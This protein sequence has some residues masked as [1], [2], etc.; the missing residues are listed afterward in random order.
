[1]A[2]QQLLLVDADPASVRVLEVS[3]K[4]AGFTVT[5]SAD[6]QDALSKLE[7]SAPDLILT[8]TRLPRVDGYE[9]VRRIKDMPGL[10]SIPIVF[11]TSQKSVE[12][13]I[14]GLE[15][16]VED[17]LTKPIFVRE[18]I[19]R[20]HL[21]LARQTHQR[22][23]TLAPTSRRTHL[24]GDLADMGVVDLLQTFE[25]GRKS[26]TATLHDGELEAAIYFRDG[27]VVD[28]EHGK[29]RGEEAIYRCLIWT[30]GTFDVEFEPINREEVIFTSTQGLL[31]EGMRRVDEWGR[32]CEQLPPLETIFRVDGE[33]LAERLNEIPD[34]LNGVLR[35]FD[36][37]RSLM[38]VV[39]ESPFEDLSTLST[40]T[41]LFF[42][43]LLTIMEPE[44]PQQEPVVPARD[45]D[46]LIPVAKPV[47]AGRGRG[48]RA[49]WR[50]SAPPVSVRAELPTPSP[51][52]VHDAPFPPGHED[53][54]HESV[55]AAPDTG[56]FESME[57]Q[58][59]DDAQR[60]APSRKPQPD[61]AP[62]I[63]PPT[64]LS[65][66]DPH[67][68]TR[69]PVSPD[70]LA[71]LMT[72]HVDS[73]PPGPTS[74]PIPE[75]QSSRLR[76]PTVDP[77]QLE[78]AAR[79]ND[80]SV[81][82]GLQSVSEA[83]RISE[84]EGESSNL[85]SSMS[86][87]SDTSRQMAVP[88]QASAPQTVP[89]TPQALLDSYGRRG[90]EAPGSAAA[91]DTLRGVALEDE[92]QAIPL[93]K[94]SRREGRSWGGNTVM[95]HR[96]PAGPDSEPMPIPLS[97]RRPQGFTSSR[98]NQPP[99]V[100]SVEPP[101]YVPPQAAG[102]SQGTPLSGETSSVGAA[103][104]SADV[105]GDA[106]SPRKSQ[107]MRSDSMAR[108]TPIHSAPTPLAPQVENPTPAQVEQEYEEESAIDSDAHPPTDEFFRSGD[109]GR[110]S[111]GPADIAAQKAAVAALEHS[112]FHEEDEVG[113][114]PGVSHARQQKMMRVVLGVVV[115]CAGVV[116]AAV[117]VPRISGDGS[118]DTPDSNPQPSSSRPTIE[119]AAPAQPDQ[120][121][122]PSVEPSLDEQD[123][124]DEGETLDE[125][126]VETK[127]VPAP[128]LKTSTPSPIAPAVR[129]TPAPQRGTAPGPAPR[130]AT[131]PAP[132]PVPS[133]T[134]SGDTASSRAVERAKAT[135]RPSENPPSAGFPDP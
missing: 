29:L 108:E 57:E 92:P 31:M 83:Q 128:A 6:G 100:V 54:G 8:D 2:K 37:S 77:D 36:G 56:A 74:D 4:K 106:S 110:Y 14:R 127:P 130:P 10:A 67:A 46:N 80:G 125:K 16:G 78:Q 87:P 99:G 39:D 104:N 126:E 116:L 122:N 59:R 86:M 40:V 105:P 90:N 63:H 97:R 50:P 72:A 44:P 88:A 79:E 103:T 115:L 101:P 15:L 17:Y 134:D 23:S 48:E 52:P 81:L 68:A 66:V 38:D 7:L 118:Q 34:E 133:P 131:S 45:S 102:A 93:Q 109:E 30:Q 47:S 51:A 62:S 117:F 132:A 61:K 135:R 22:M 3:L 113:P 85:K 25:M 111:G 73:V 24:S 32:L 11:L 119:S 70:R 76:R 95:G 65:P 27:K 75:S 123:P 69:G 112:S 18:L 124:A 98:A 53:H 5:T 21:L 35:L 129:P 82:I 20:V 12:D 91:T 84:E 58:R 71:G 42:E 43:G 28:A 121:S 96:N 19:A 64:S 1:M 55:P 60:R 13:K 26:G 89:D 107:T 41:K 9:L 114:P 94:P 49:S 33:L 120:T